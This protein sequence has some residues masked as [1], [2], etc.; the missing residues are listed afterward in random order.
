MTTLT[1]RNLIQGATA[2]AG[3]ALA[4]PGIA[5]AAAAAPATTAA[6]AAGVKALVYDVF[7]T[8]VDWRNGV[9][10]D[11]ER[12]LKPLGYSLDWIGF[13]DAWRALYQPSMEEIRSGKR[14]FVKL[15]ILHREMLEKIKPRFGLQKL[16]DKVSAD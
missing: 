6:G 12:I 15:D 16:D 11:A 10:K 13:A 7:G 5:T 9:A 14:P 1:R 4:G 3:A 2:L 8:C